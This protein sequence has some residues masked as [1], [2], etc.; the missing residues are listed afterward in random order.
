M[1][2]LIIGLLACAMVFAGTPAFAA[3]SDVPQASPYEQ[4][5]ANLTACGILA[6]KPGGTFD[7]DGMLTR[8]EFAKIAV[9]VAG[10]Q[11]D[12]AKELFADVPPSHWANGYIAAAAHNGL[13]IGYPDGMFKPDEQISF[14]QA[15]TI[16]LRLMGYDSTTTSFRWPDEYLLKAKDLALTADMD[17]DAQSP[18]TRGNAAILLDRAL[19]TGMRKASA[20]S[21]D[22]LL[23]ERMGLSL[24]KRIVIISSKKE[25]GS[26]T[27]NEI[28]T[29]FG[30]YAS[31][32]DL[33]AM[34]SK[35]GKLVLNEDN[36]IVHFIPDQQ[37]SENRV[38]SRTYKGSVS[39][40]N[41]DDVPMKDESIVYFEGKKMSYSE[42]RDELTHGAR[43]I[44]YRATNG[45]LDY[46]YVRR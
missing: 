22:R 38:L 19:V 43:V 29:D 17:Q 33:E 14:A 46:M 16:V 4:P 7:P 40:T 24:S 1:K 21:K 35:K 26:L 9:I 12:S 23:L 15:I 25:D 30:T 34:I 39:F 42:V 32:V 18:I 2:R 13:L 45:G 44:V 20:Y 10:L 36:E 8:A 11:E 31:L 37:V 3:Y 5:A 27:E 28:K 6:G 41:G